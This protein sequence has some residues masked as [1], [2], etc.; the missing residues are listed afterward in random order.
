[1]WHPKCHMNS[2]FSTPLYTLKEWSFLDKVGLMCQIGTAATT[3]RYSTGRVSRAA[4]R[5]PYWLDGALL[6]DFLTNSRWL[7]HFLSEGQS[8]RRLISALPPLRYQRQGMA[9][10]HTNRQQLHEDSSNW[11]SIP[12]VKRVKLWAAPSPDTHTHTQAHVC[13]SL[14][15][16]TS[17]MIHYMEWR[18]GKVHIPLAVWQIFLFWCLARCSCPGSQPPVRQKHLSQFRWLWRRAGV[19]AMFFL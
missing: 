7:Y 1:M 3:R 2:S 5:C 15:S 8:V 9:L 4:S 12:L 6:N 17:R 14:R 19:D 16:I 10:T 13:L 11:A 18:G